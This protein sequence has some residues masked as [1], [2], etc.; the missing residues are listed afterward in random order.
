MEIEY[1]APISLTER[2]ENNFAKLRSQTGIASS[3]SGSARTVPRRMLHRRAKRI[4]ADS[5][6]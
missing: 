5:H 3:Q 6:C 1:R 2:L 4:R